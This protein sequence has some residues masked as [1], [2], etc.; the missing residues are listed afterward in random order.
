[1]IAEVE[2]NPDFYSEVDEPN[3]IL[4]NYLDVHK[5]ERDREGTKCRSSNWEE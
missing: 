4:F 5:A 1:M 3:F 2:F